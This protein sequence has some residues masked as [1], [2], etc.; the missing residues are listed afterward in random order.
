MAGGGGIG[1]QSSKHAAERSGADMTTY[2]TSKGGRHQRVCYRLSILSTT[3]AGIIHAARDNGRSAS[4]ALEITFC[5]SVGAGDVLEVT[6]TL[7]VTSA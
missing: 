1:E 2:Q 7:I 5:R 4:W 6:K 3:A